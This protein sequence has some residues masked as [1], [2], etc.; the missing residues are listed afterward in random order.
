[1][2]I[3]LAA[4][5]L[6][7]GEEFYEGWMQTRPSTSMTMLPGAQT[8]PA[9][10][11]ALSGADV[12]AREAPGT[13]PLSS[14]APLS[15][16][17][18]TIIN[19][20]AHR[21]L[22]VMAG[23][24]MAHD[25]GRGA[26][27]GLDADT[28]DRLGKSAASITVGVADGSPLLGLHSRSAELAAAGLI[29]HATAQRHDAELGQWITTLAPARL[30]RAAGS[31]AAGGVAFLLAAHGARL[32]T[33]SQAL[34]EEHSWIDHVQA[35]DLV[36]TLSETD[37]PVD[38]LSGVTETLGQLCRAGAIPHAV[39]GEVSGMPRRELASSGVTDYYIRRGRSYHTLGATLAA[40]W[41]RA[42]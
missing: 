8:D 16:A 10:W 23:Q 40:T 39:V 7:I 31:A 3:V 36:I 20:A 18:A 6:A 14:T 27:E 21:P 33:W 1:M 19:A 25:A 41:L 26:Y 12:E 9:L 15:N 13:R 29:T 4:P 17:L 42:P 5:N 34:S 30:A 38:M 2:D 24:T 37:D 32:V 28:R 11:P 35:A 22:T